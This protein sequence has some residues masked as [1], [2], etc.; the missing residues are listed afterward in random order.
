MANERSLRLFTAAN[1]QVEVSASTESTERLVWL[2]ALDAAQREAIKACMEIAER[3]EP[4]DA[5]I[6]AMRE[7]L[8][9]LPEG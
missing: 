4:R 5:A 6:S 8:K 9:E 3:Y 2:R 1:Y 7:L